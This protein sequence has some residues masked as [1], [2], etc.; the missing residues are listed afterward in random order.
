M[1]QVMEKGRH[2][3]KKP[4]QRVF[5]VR[6]NESCHKNL[7]GLEKAADV[8]KSISQI[9]VITILRYPL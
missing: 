2:A 5:S 7:L 1:C 6:M 3:S 9:N 4:V 8:P